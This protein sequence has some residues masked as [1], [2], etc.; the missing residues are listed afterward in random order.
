M[1][2]DTRLPLGQDALLVRDLKSAWLLRDPP[3]LPS[4]SHAQNKHEY[5]RALVSEQGTSTTGLHGGSN[6]SGNGSGS[7]SSSSDAG[8]GGVKFIWWFTSVRTGADKV[9]ATQTAVESFEGA[10]FGVDE[11]LRRATI[12]TDRDVIARAAELVRVTCPEAREEP[13]PSLVEPGPERS[14][15]E[16]RMALLRSR[17]RSQTS[18]SEGCLCLITCL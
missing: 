14:P 7:A 10:F 18:V 1:A 8:I 13:G 5:S 9:D 17:C 16:T 4:H 6:N 15:S 11:A 2:Y 12:Q 3:A